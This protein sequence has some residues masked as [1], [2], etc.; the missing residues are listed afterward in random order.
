MS[1][2]FC[3]AL[4]VLLLSACSGTRF[5]RPPNISVP[6]GFS[7]EVAIYDQGWMLVAASVYGGEGKPR[8]PRIESNG[9][10][11]VLAQGSV[12]ETELPITSIAFYDGQVYVVQAGTVSII[13]EGGQLRNT[14]GLPGDGDHQANQLV[15]PGNF[16]YLSIGI[17]TISRVIGEDYPVQKPKE[18]MGSGIPI[19]DVLFSI[20]GVNQDWI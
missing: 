16:M 2:W 4:L 5:I 14:I 18:L 11:T 15:F 7:V 13:E 19:G 12:F 6:E 3:T 20:H 8:V 17:V 10:K 1:R 9:E